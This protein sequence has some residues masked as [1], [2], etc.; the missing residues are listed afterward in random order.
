MNSG[1]ARGPRAPIV[2]LSALALVGLVV[3]GCAPVSE[4]G[5]SAG[6]IAA[7]TG[8]VVTNELVVDGLERS[9]LLR[10]PVRAVAD[11]PLPL[12]ILI[13]GAGGNAK[14]AEDATG[15]TALSDAEGFIVAYPNGTQAADVPGEFSWNAGACCGRPV[16]DDI[17]DVKFIE[18][19]IADVTKQQPVDPARIYVAGFSNGGMLAYRLACELPGTLAGIAVIAGALNYDDCDAAAATP[20][21]MVHGTGDKTVPYKGGATNERTAK[22][23]GQWNN[24][25]LADSISFWVG[26]DGCIDAPLRMVDGGVTRETF[27]GCGSD[28]TVEVVTIADGGHIWP[29]AAES[30]FDA[31]DLITEFFGLGQ[32]E[33]ALAR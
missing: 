20:V 19:M 16:K 5:A 15:M 11:D 3:A 1:R 4:P 25:S 17:D 21:L 9:Y 33:L 26:R 8:A 22:R 27:S 31:S 10:S 2:L 6:A 14:K 18:A 28:A 13:H 24:A 23:F 32:P 30:G 7:A 29:V 12:L